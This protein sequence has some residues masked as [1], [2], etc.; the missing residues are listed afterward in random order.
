MTAVRE[1]TIGHYTTASRHRD[2]LA[3]SVPVPT[4]VEHDIII[5]DPLATV[6]GR[7]VTTP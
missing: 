6:P 4:L 5:S 1:L 3:A 2:A 7:K